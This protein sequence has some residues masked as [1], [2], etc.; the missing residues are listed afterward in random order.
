MRGQ[1]EAYFA[2]LG[3]LG[4]RTLATNQK[5]ESVTL[6]AAMTWGLDTLQRVRRDRRRVFF[7]GNGGSAGIAS[8]MATDWMKTGGFSALAFN[9]GAMLTCLSNDLG[10]DNVFAVPLAHHAGNND[11]LIAISSSGRSANILAGVRAARSVGAQIITLSGFGAD[12]PLRTQGEMNFYVPNSRYGFVEIAH[13][14]ICHSLL[15][16]A[17]GWRANGDE[18]RYVTQA[19]MAP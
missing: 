2:T 19:G 11:L 16:L 7:I 17:M 4:A 1:V 5:G 18:P 8:H 9:D 14:T 12:N 10:Y 6:D 3:E 15:D 13:L